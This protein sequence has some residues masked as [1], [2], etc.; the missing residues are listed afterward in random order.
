M[1][2]C[3][4]QIPGSA[5]ALKIVYLGDPPINYFPPAKQ[6]AIPQIP[7]H[8]FCLT[9]FTTFHR[10]T[11][12]L[13]KV[14]TV[15]YVFLFLVV[16][17]SCLLI[18]SSSSDERG[19]LSEDW[20]AKMSTFLGSMNDALSLDSWWSFDDDDDVN[21]NDIASLSGG[22][23]REFYST[24]PEPAEAAGTTE[25]K[26]R[27]KENRAVGPKEVT[28]LRQ[29]YIDDQKRLTIIV[30]GAQKCGTSAMAAYLA[31]HPSVEFA[32]VSFCFVKFCFVKFC[33][34]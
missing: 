10:P 9:T 4:P 11:N 29:K 14:R 13:M 27:T 25:E 28:K 16:V 17:G 1:P 15:G 21:P 31:S 6:K 32:K 8:L 5:T 7:A 30:A 3:A 22:A 34:H 33:K 20:N 12:F 2:L 23:A 18:F 26:P 19:S 24:T